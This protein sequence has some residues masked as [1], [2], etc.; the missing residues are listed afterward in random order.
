MD[1]VPDNPGISPAQVVAIVR[2]R[3]WW[4]VLPLFFGWALVAT[5]GWML[6]P[7]YKSETTILIEQ[8]KVPEHYVVPNVSVDLQ[9]RLQSLSQQILSRT[10]LLAIIDKFQ[11]Y[12]NRRG[13]TDPDSLVERMRK[14]IDI[15]L[16]RGQKQDDLSAFKI[17]YSASDPLMAQQVAG[18]LT[19]LF[20]NENLKNREELSV[21]T[22]AFLESQLQDAQKS[23]NAQEQRLREFKSKY[24][25]ELPEQLQSNLQI[26]TGLQARLQTAT[27]A[28]NQ[29]QQ[30]RLYLQSLQSQYKAITAQTT[31]VA[32]ADGQGG[33]VTLPA[34]EQHLTQLNSQLSELSAKYTPQ[35]PD[36]IR[37][38]NEIASTEKL[39]KQFEADLASG[40]KNKKTGTGTVVVGNLQTANPILQVEGQLEANKLE[41]ANRQKEI[42]SLEADIEDYQHRLNLTPVRE[43]EFA[44]I[45]RDHDQSQKNYESLLARKLQSEEATNLE[46]RQQGETF[47]VLDP[48]NLPQK[49]YSPNRLIFC[50][51]GIAV[52]LALGLGLA[53]LLELLNPRVHCEADLRQPGAAPFLVSIPR[54]ATA[55]ER[56]QQRRRLVFEALTMAAMVAAISAGS[57]LTYW[58]G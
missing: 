31:A 4:I 25:G 36:V 12:P 11:L 56:G 46:R 43:Q 6:P 18:E 30:Q 23:L 53:L 37:L 1:S 13:K 16:V 44:A 33:P 24:L 27:D 42:K 34:I 48:P 7:R 26:L 52:G 57:L 17:S 51:G 55:A 10:R 54:L 41:I 28:L 9:D 3:R 58:K 8:Q 5:V 14:D 21:Q 39:K 35:H 38:K 49:P 32:P 19:S 2:R 50:L 15:E 40:D 45:T 22:T 47:R 29:A 20:I